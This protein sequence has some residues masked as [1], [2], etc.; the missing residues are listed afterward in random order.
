MNLP[1]LMPL[2]RANM[3]QGKAVPG[4]GVTEG[5]GVA[6]LGGKTSGSTMLRE[7]HHLSLANGATLDATYNGSYDGNANLFKEQMTLTGPELLIS[8]VLSGAFQRSGFRRHHHYGRC[9][10]AT[11]YRRRYSANC[12]EPDHQER[13]S[14]ADA[15]DTAMSEGG[16][17]D[18]DP[19]VDLSSSCSSWPKGGPHTPPVSPSLSP[20][21][22]WWSRDDGGGQ[23]WAWVEARFLG[24][25][26]LRREIPPALEEKLQRMR[27]RGWARGR[28]RGLQER[29]RNLHL[30]L[31]GAWRG[32]GQHP[33]PR[34]SMCRSCSL[35]FSSDEAADQ[36]SPT[37]KL[38]VHK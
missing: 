32:E 20:D 13:E 9:P 19:E 28:L 33:S 25:R 36:Q 23:D 27:A 22:R 16:D 18:N 21:D 1:L 29:V 7:R 6:L 14:L 4:G 10:D 3:A 31:G 5:A 35:T 15:S 17:S 8:R 12:I 2:P 26:R 37:G 30:G 34:D 11:L 38:K 24:L